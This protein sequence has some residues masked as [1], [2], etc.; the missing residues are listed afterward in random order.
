MIY[1]DNV[2]PKYYFALSVSLCTSLN[3]KTSIYKTLY[4]L[5]Q[6]ALNTVR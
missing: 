4:L 3:L 2:F 6:A 5:S 1:M